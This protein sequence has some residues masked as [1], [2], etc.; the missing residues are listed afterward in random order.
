MERAFPRIEG[1]Y[2]GNQSWFPR[3]LWAAGSCGVIAA[4]NVYYYYYQ[5][6]LEPDRAEYMALSTALYHWLKPVNAFNPFYHEDTLGILSVSLWC[7]RALRFFRIRGL[8]LEAQIFRFIR[9]KALV[10]AKKALLRGELPVLFVLGTPGSTPYTNHIMVLTGFEKERLIVST[11]GEKR[12]IPFSELARA[13][14]FFH[15]VVFKRP[16]SP[17]KPQ[18]YG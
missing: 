7:Q 13:G 17:P 12:T 5:G 16:L 8:A 18:V 3:S 14:N 6:T 2:G 10:E 4:A 11:W 1:S 15:L 9:Q